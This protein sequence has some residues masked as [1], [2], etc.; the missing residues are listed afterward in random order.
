MKR[1]AA[2]LGLDH[3]LAMHAH[4][5]A[6]AADVALGV[7]LPGRARAPCQTFQMRLRQPGVILGVDQAPDRARA[8]TARCAPRRAAEI[9][10]DDVEIDQRARR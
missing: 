5:R 4:G 6:I 7:F 9:E 10:Q 8:T 2:R 1:I 3:D